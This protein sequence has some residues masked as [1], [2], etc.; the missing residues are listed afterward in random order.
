MLVSCEKDQLDPQDFTGVYNST[1]ILYLDKPVMY[2][3]TGQV[4]DSNIIKAYID[5]IATVVGVSA[6]NYFSFSPSIA[7]N[8]PISITLN[9]GEGTFN[10]NILWGAG[11]IGP[12][13]NVKLSSLSTSEYMMEIKDTLQ[14]V[15]NTP[16]TPCEIF[17]LQWSRYLPNRVE[18]S[19]FS[20]QQYCKSIFTIPLKI[21]NSNQIDLPLQSRA[22]NY[23]PRS[24]S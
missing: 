7:V 12:T 24:I 9:E 14:E 8:E 15:I 20:S 2:T 13:L 19:L 23:L 10:Q 11:P 1:N 16:S 3:T 4:T 21:E 22:L 5:R 17:V 18:C 6:Q